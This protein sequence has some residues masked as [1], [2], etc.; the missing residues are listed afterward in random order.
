MLT[1]EIYKKVQ[2]TAEAANGDADKTVIAAQGTGKKLRI[3]KAIVTVT[4]AAA[5]AGGEVALEDGVGGTRFFEADADAVGVYVVD[6]GEEGYDL[7]ADTL[8]NLTVD[9]SSGNQATARCTA[10]AVVLQ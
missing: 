9:G 7:S 8:L 6:F 10:I 5:A 2:G 3:K 1:G 4:V